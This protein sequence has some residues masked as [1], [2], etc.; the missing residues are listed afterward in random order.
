MLK[1]LLISA[2]VFF[3]TLIISTVIGLI[4]NNPKRKQRGTQKETK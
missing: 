1:F 4:I 3:G 2:A